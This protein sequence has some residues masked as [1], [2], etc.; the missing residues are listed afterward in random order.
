MNSRLDILYNWL[1]SMGFSDMNNVRVNTLVN[2]D[3]TY[4][5]GLN[6]GGGVN[7]LKEKIGVDII[8]TVDNTT[9]YSMYMFFRSTVSF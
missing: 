9:P 1:R 8:S 4:G 3:K 2:E 6:F 7:L 5:I